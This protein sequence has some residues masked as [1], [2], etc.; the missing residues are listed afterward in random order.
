[1]FRTKLRATFIL[2]LLGVF[3]LSGA[4]LAEPYAPI[5]KDP[6]EPTIKDKEAFYPLEKMMLQALAKKVP[7]RRAV[8]QPPYPG[9]VIGKAV[10]AGEM[11][12]GEGTFTALPVVVLH[13]TD[14]VPK[15][16]QFYVEALPDWSKLTRF[17]MEFLYEGSGE[18]K[19][20]RKSSLV[21]PNIV[22]MELIDDLKFHA[23]PDA[24][25]EIMIY[26]K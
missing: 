18:F 14:D 3:Y 4:A 1:M 20:M 12:S 16:L 2:G 6:G 19:P 25:T 15:V 10:L 21:T 26:Y 17:G 11:S 5:A 8:K 22:I 9:A 24:K 23:M 7:D 13:T